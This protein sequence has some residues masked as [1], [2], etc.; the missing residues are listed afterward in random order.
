[1]SVQ[2]NVFPPAAVAEVRSQ[3]RHPIVDADGHH[4]EILPV[5]VDCARDI[6]GPAAAE[7]L[8]RHYR[9]DIAEVRQIPT[10][11]ARNYWTF[12]TEN[13]LDRVTASLPELMYR[14]LDEV[15]IDFA[16]IF[17]SRG[18]A[19]PRVRDDE[20][21]QLS[22]RALNTYYAR[23]FEPFRDRL[24]PVAVIPTFTPEEACAELDYAVGELGLK[25][26]VMGGV[27]PRAAR[28][29]GTPEPWMDTLGHGSVYDYDP[30]WEACVRY[31]VVPQFHA[32]GYGWGSRVSL[33]NYV[34]NH[35]GNFASA[36]EATC[37]SLVMGGVPQR[38]PQLRFSFLEGG[39]A[40]AAQLY[41]DLLGHYE[42]RNGE[43]VLQYDP[44]RLDL[45]LVSEL[46]D[47]HAGPMVRARRSEWE[48]VLADDRA[49]HGR[50]D[51]A[52]TD[53]WAESGITGPDDIVD[54]F[55]NRFFFG[56]E[57]DDPMNAIAF[58]RTLLPHGI[59][60]NA[61]FASDIGHWDVTDIRGVLPE[62]WELV[63]HGLL[64]HDDFADFTWRG[65]TRMLT[66][67]NP[68]FFDGTVVDAR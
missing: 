68:R 29:D 58:Q 64:D 63:D 50:I 10:R 24:E 55:S 11:R 45:A 4:V 15:G 56:C 3:I 49:T 54:L 1:M 32:N 22:A 26:V 28:P 44:A 35:I 38:F 37:R 31:G 43:A 36:Q 23:A 61:M 14:R 6:A 39:V 51:P 48:A 16:L 42:K 62:A 7:R 5:V 21:R 13:T 34:Y 53:D 20:D 67:V 41:S 18:L 19:V 33:T 30:V 9:S 46:L 66:D 8:E 47:R 59:R 60:L 57:A 27:V 65:V 25:T 17:P 12:P 40:W 2:E 52:T